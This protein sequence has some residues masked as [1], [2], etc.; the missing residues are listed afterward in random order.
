MI[1]L[2]YLTRCR[3]GDFGVNI[4]GHILPP[5]LD[6]VVLNLGHQYYQ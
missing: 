4:G 3:I 1:M 5:S 2:H 6:Q